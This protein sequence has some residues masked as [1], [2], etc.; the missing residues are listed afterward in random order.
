[1][2]NNRTS[3]TEEE[4]KFLK[5]HS[6]PYEKSLPYVKN[7]KCLLEIVQ[8]HQEG[9]TLRMMEAMF[10]NKKIVTNNQNIKNYDF[11]DTRNIYILNDDSRSLVEFVL[12]DDK[13]EWNQ[14]FVEAYSFEHWLHNFF[15][16]KNHV[17]DN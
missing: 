15:L 10:F 8:T 2:G 6:L 17:G 4:T 3:Y 14:S 1:V 9:L 13:A 16:S 7:T 12:G 11:Y 5:P